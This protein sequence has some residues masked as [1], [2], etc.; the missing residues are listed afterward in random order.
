MMTNVEQDYE[1]QRISK[2]QQYRVLTRNMPHRLA[3][4]SC[5]DQEALGLDQFGNNPT[6]TQVDTFICQMGL[7]P[8]SMS[9]RQQIQA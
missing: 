2:E 3:Y 9:I 8:S 6:P 4:L 5:R 7:N 1:E